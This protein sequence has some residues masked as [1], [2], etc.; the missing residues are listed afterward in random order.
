MSTGTL[1]GFPAR[2][3]KA[4]RPL[5]R[6]HRSTRGAWWFS[7]DGTGRFDPVRAGGLGACYFAQDPL[8]AFVEVF[9]TRI[10]LDQDDVDERRLARVELNHDLRLA[11]LTSRRALRF[12]VTAEIG[13][14]GDYDASQRL[15]AGLAAAGYDGIRWWVRHDPR[16]QLAG[17][18]IFGPAGAPSSKARTPPPDSRE[19]GASL[20][21]MARR[22]F[23][24]RMVP[25]P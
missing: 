22:R 20:L 4:G 2:T 11:D 1:S 5:W 19:I 14:G 23:G 24:Y 8:G 15:A 3:W 7:D 18:A 6:I 21:E 12:G 9:R 17:I 25:R 16:Q 13:A 10:E